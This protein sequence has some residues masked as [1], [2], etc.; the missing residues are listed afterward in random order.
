M[1]VRLSPHPDQIR[2]WV[3]SALGGF[4]T[5][6]RETAIAN[7]KGDLAALLAYLDRTDDATRVLGVAPVEATVGDKHG[8]GESNGSNKPHL[9][10]VRP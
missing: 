3:Q 2:W 1:I 8:V 5:L 7:A 6:D 10:V 9:E 4:D